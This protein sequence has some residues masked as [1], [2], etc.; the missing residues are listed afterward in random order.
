MDVVVDKRSGPAV[1]DS[2]QPDHDP[3]ADGAVLSEDNPIELSIDADDMAGKGQNVSPRPLSR[4]AFIA[5][6]QVAIAGVS[7]QVPITGRIRSAAGGQRFR[8]TS[9]EF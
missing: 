8:L 4:F 1:R 3:V 5:H 7:V 9:R 2:R 6:K